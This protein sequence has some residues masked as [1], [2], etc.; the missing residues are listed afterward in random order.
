LEWLKA[1]RALASR[2]W[3][4]I[5]KIN[6]NSY[7]KKP[8]H[9]LTHLLA[10]KKFPLLTKDEQKVKIRKNSSLILKVI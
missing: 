5:A 4:F 7:P 3:S 10:L 8:V 6:H 2:I 1:D 9:A